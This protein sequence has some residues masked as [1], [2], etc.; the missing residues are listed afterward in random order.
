MIRNMPGTLNFLLETP[1]H[2]RGSSGI[3]KLAPAVLSLRP[4]LPP[5][6]RTSDSHGTKQ[7]PT[8]QGLRG[9]MLLRS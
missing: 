5:H 7:K 2:S 8:A 9:L 6:H 1:L 3:A 4:H